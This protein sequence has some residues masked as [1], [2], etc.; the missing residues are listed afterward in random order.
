MPEHYEYVEGRLEVLTAFGAFALGRDLVGAVAR[1]R[2]RPARLREV[3]AALQSGRDAL[4]AW[5]ADAPIRRQDRAARMRLHRRVEVEIRVCVHADYVI[6]SQEDGC[7]HW[8]QAPRPV[9]RGNPE[10]TIRA[11]VRAQLVRLRVEPRYLRERLLDLIGERL[12]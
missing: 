11:E 10:K 12:S 9:G 6:W 2:L 1:L 3:A 4:R 8:R 5:R 7:S